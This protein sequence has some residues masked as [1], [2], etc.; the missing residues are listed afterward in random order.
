MRSNGEDGEDCSFFEGNGNLPDRIQIGMESL[1]RYLGAGQKR[2][3]S[4]M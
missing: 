2:S 3:S 4:P 1:G